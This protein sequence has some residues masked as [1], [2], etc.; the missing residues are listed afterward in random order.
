MSVKNS[1]V[2]LSKLKKKNINLFL[3]FKINR[4]LCNY[5]CSNYINWFLFEK[6]LPTFSIVIQRVVRVFNFLC[7]K[8]TLQYLTECS[9]S[10][11]QFII[12]QKQLI[13][14]HKKMTTVEQTI[15]FAAGKEE[16]KLKTA[17]DNRTIQ[18]FFYCNIAHSSLS[19]LISL[20]HKLQL[21]FKIVLQK[22]QLHYQV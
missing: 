8:I 9:F 11:T 14:K 6:I 15:K 2:L 7:M 3:Q 10:S 20:T 18:K 16:K 17:I 19:N 21:K 22:Q 4:V 5:T 1:L 12:L 13:L